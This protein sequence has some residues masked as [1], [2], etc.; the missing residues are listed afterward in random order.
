M[1]GM[2]RS[3]SLNSPLQLFEAMVSFNLT[4]SAIALCVIPIAR[5]A[6]TR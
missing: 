3:F 1:E 5:I 4:I 2:S 6:Q